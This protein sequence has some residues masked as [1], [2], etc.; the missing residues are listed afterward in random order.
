MW[1]KNVKKTIF[2]VNVDNYAPEITELTY[3]LI[4][5]YAHKIK[6]DFHIITD[7][8]FPNRPPVYEKMQIY[9]LGREMENDWNIYIDS[10]A[11]V[12]P[13]L[14]DVT[15]FITKDTVLHTGNDLAS[16]RWRYDDYF[17]R[18]GRHI[19]SCNWFTVAS[20]YCLDLWHPLDITYEEALENIFP[21]QNELNT[22]I[23]RDH[24]IDDYMLSRNIARFGL[25]FTT[26]FALAEKHKD[27]G[28]YFWHQYTIGIKEKVEMMKN[29]LCVWG[30]TDYKDPH[31]EGWMQK[32]ELFWLYLMAKDMG[33]VAEVGIWKGKG[34][35]ALASGCKGQIHSIDNFKFAPTEEYL[36]FSE[37]FLIPFAGE[38]SLDI[39][40]M[41]K[42]STKDLPNVELIKMDSVSAA[43]KFANNSVDMIWLDAGHDYSSVMA[44]IKAWLP[45]CKKMLCGHDYDHESVRRALFDSHL[46]VA[47]PWDNSRI[48]YVVKE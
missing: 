17:R 3:P 6:A 35:H 29:T 30:A 22:V 44:D 11:L 45:K 7:R 26:M 38:P 40:K 33:S 34:T 37:K 27:P 10:D 16:N 42:H 32:G 2:T 8:K 13:D 5:R 9:D 25:K 20:N 31:I 15:E 39:E 28:G 36:G 47:Q 48:W 24:L 14:F 41:F 46:L 19:G 21:I 12:H 23:T 18:D 43:E 4:R 1:K